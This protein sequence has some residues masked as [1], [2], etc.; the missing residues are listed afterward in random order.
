MVNR[1]FKVRG[2][3]VGYEAR[4]NDDVFMH[5]LTYIGNNLTGKF[6]VPTTC[7]WLELY[8]SY[9]IGQPSEDNSL[10]LLLSGKGSS[11]L[12]YGPRI[13]TTL[14][15]NVSG[16]QGCSCSAYGHASPTRI[17]WLY[18]PS[19]LVDDVAATYGTWRARWKGRTYLSRK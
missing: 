2:I 1:N 14:K 4:V 9:A 13:A 6:K 12:K 11:S 17:G 16:T 19:E 15:G 7:F 3:R 8:P 10:Y 5:K 18:G